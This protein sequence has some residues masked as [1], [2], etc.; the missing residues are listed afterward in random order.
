MT[1]KEHGDRRRTNDDGRVL[2]FA[3]IH[4]RP[5]WDKK[6]TLTASGFMGSKGVTGVIIVCIWV[7]TGM[8]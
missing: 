1:E 8:V 2:A 5:K 6:L 7:L 3:I 4:M